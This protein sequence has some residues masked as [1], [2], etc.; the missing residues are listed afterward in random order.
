MFI[1]VISDSSEINEEYISI[2]C[3]LALHNTSLKKL[4]YANDLF[5]LNYLTHTIFHIFMFYCIIS[6]YG[7]RT[8]PADMHLLTIKIISFSNI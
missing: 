3:V 1:L 7:S 2:L 4:C 5:T 8:G 6:T